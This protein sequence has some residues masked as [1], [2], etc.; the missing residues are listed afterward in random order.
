ME[1]KIEDLGNYTALLISI[2]TVVFAIY[3]QEMF[4]GH[5]LWNYLVL[6]TDQSQKFSKIFGF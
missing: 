4:F 6:K 3:S 1:E 5:I 2:A